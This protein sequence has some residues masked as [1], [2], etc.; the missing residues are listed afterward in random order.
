M[1]SRATHSFRA[2]NYGQYILS[3]EQEVKHKKAGSS[4]SNEEG[5]MSEI[6]RHGGQSWRW[7]PGAIGTKYCQ[8]HG[9]AKGWVLNHPGIVFRREG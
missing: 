8:W 4:E 5:A 2:I 3:V 1:V 9:M 6:Y 7:Q